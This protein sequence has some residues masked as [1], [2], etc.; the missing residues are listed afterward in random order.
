MTRQQK[1]AENRTMGKLDNE[2]TLKFTQRELISIYNVLGHNPDGSPKEYRIGDGHI[3]F[4]ILEKL[5]PLVVVET[6]IPPE[7]QGKQPPP[8][9]EEKIESTIIGVDADGE[10]EEKIN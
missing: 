10:K 7:E 5:Q 1:R 2:Y 3:V 6:N 4:G 9:E 8:P